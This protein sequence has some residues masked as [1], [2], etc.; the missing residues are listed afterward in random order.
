MVEGEQSCGMPC[1]VDGCAL[2]CIIS[3]AA[4]ESPWMM[5]CMRTLDCWHSCAIVPGM[6]GYWWCGW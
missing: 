1:D 4:V 3:G 6:R 5:F 2:R